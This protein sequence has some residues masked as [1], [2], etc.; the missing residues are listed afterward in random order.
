MALHLN[1]VLLILPFVDFLKNRDIDL[2]KKWKWTV[3][4]E[5]EKKLTHEGEEE[6]LL[7]AERMQSRFPEVFDNVYSN[8][9]YKVQ[10]Y[11]SNSS[12]N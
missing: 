12:F 6:M 3:K 2:L 4:L 9:T 8:T 11:S 5:D 1:K 10:G 7:M